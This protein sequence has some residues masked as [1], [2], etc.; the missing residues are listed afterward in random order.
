MQAALLAVAGLRGGLAYGGAPRQ[1]RIAGLA[2]AIIALAVQ[3]GVAL[4]LGR[5]PAQLGAPL[6][7]PDPTALLTLALLL[8]ARRAHWSLY[9]VPLAWCAVSTLTLAAMEAEAAEALVPALGGLAALGAALALRP[10][11]TAPATR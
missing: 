10:L 5:P 6:L 7:A 4:A 2:I 9:A 8:A 1:R 3:P 11:R